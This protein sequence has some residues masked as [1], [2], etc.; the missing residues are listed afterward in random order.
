[1]E[2]WNPGTLEPCNCGTLKLLNPG[3]ME[4]WRLELWN[5]GTMDLWNPEAIL[6]RETISPFRWKPYLEPRNP[7]TMEHWKYGTL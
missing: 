2:L 4:S 6:I 7:G 1:M 5:Y 3:T